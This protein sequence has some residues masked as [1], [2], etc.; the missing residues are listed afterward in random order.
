[1][2]SAHLTKIK[3]AT[4]FIAFFP[5]CAYSQPSEMALAN[6]PYIENCKTPILHPEQAKELRYPLTTAGIWYTANAEKSPDAALDGSDF[7]VSWCRSESHVSEQYALTYKGYR[8]HTFEGCNNIISTNSTV[9]G[10]LI[11]NAREA[12]MKGMYDL[13]SEKI[14]PDFVHTG[15][16]ILSYQGDGL[17]S[18][19]VCP[20]GKWLAT[21]FH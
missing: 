14:V 9:E 19:F 13:K 15:P 2:L 7:V 5:Y 21:V 11:V 16:V 17:L 10:L 3:C 12:V 1:M 6:N 8:Q 18:M 20:D 4:L